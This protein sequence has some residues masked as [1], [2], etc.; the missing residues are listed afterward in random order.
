MW[1]MSGSREV[2][3]VMLNCDCVKVIGLV[4]GSLM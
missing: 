3:M 1:V 4:K 2:G